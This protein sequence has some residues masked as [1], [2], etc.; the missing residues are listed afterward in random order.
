MKKKII[1]L[2]IVGALA[3]AYGTVRAVDEPQKTVLPL[4]TIIGDGLCT[5]N[6][7]KET[8]SCQGAIKVKEEDKTTVYYLVHNDVSKAFHDTICKDTAQVRATG[9]LKE[10]LGKLQLTPIK[11]E[12]VK[13][14][15]AESPP[16]RPDARNDAF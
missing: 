3:V 12:L 5:K 8:T 10:V 14:P 15:P 4:K 6:A 7:L 11:I 9:T 16:V 13:E 2:L 1:P